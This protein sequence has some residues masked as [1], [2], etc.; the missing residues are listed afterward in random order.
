MGCFDT[1]PALC[2]LENLL[3]IEEERK[4]EQAS[5][6]YYVCELSSQVLQLF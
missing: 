5:M 1:H 4:K 2:C 3:A 6:S